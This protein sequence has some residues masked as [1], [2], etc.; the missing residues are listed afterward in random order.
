MLYT[1]GTIFR[2]GIQLKLQHGKSAVLLSNIDQLCQE[3]FDWHGKVGL[4]SVSAKKQDLLAKQLHLHCWQC[5]GF[6]DISK[7]FRL[8]GTHFPAP[9]GQH[10]KGSVSA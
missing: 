2:S 7:V 8:D 9:H 1:G 3:I 5:K 10:Q 4:D 6:N